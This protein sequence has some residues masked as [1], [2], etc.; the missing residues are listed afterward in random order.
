MFTRIASLLLPSSRKHTADYPLVPD[1]KPEQ[2]LNQIALLTAQ[3]ALPHCRCCDDRHTV[4]VCEPPAE[5]VP[6]R[7]HRSL[8]AA[9]QHHSG[10][11][12][13]GCCAEL[14]EPGS[15]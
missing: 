9:Q 4:Q 2:V 7:C 11:S 8:I 5:A 13:R 14:L 15:G 12:D 3:Q 6:R 1:V 10:N